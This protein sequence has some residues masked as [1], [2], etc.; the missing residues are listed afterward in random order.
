MDFISSSISSSQYGFLRGRSI[1]QQLLVFFN[2]IFS[3][4]FPIDVVY[5]D[6]R[7]AFDSVAHN[8]LLL[9]LEIRH[10]WYIPYGYGLEPISLIE[11]SV[12]LLANLFLLLYLSFLEFHKAVFLV[13]SYFFFL[14]MI[15]L[16]QFLSPKFCFLLMMPSVCYL[17]HL[18]K[19]TFISNLT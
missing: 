1:L 16:H 11:S 15:L 17:F 19:I 18:Y 8:E 2:T 9:K 14:S 12:C 5:L 6:F 3:S 13:S 4:P 10:H 7:K